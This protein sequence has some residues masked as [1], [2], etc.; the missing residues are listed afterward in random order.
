MDNE[1]KKFWEN[2]F[3]NN[4]V[5]YD[6]AG[7]EIRKGSYGQAG[8]EYGWNIDHI[9]PRSMGGTDHYYN[10]Q[11]THIST[12]SER[13]NRMSFWIDGSL[14]Q[15]KKITRLYDDDKVAAYP[16]NDKKYCI[17]ILEKETEEEYSQDYLDDD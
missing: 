5:G 4:E 12:N 14:Y 7:Y 16:Y 8:S 1:V 17:I 11:I 6:F 10:L 2:E 15:V 13:G 9:L 3:G